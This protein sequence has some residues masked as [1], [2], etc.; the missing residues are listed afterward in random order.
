MQCLPWYLIFKS[1]FAWDHRWKIYFCIAPFVCSASAIYADKRASSWLA[2]LAVSYLFDALDSFLASRQVLSVNS[3]WALLSRPRPYVPCQLLC[4]C[5]NRRPCKE[6]TGTKRTHW[7]TFDVAAL[8]L[9]SFVRPPKYVCVCVPA[10]PT[11]HNSIHN[12]LPARVS[13]EM[14]WKFLLHTQWARRDSF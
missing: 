8:S 9:L 2:S 11:I 5:V 6:L 14:L 4:D 13:E 1:R 7:S 10:P 12:L 3:H